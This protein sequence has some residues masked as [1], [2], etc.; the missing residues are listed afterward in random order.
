MGKLGF[1]DSL[2]PLHTPQRQKPPQFYIPTYLQHLASN[3]HIVAMT[4][5]SVISNSGHQLTNDH[6]IQVCL[7]SMLLFQHTVEDCI[8][9]WVV[10]G[11]F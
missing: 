3:W 8:I 1:I 11:K 4:T 2:T 7:F 5:K 10:K 6:F 9:P